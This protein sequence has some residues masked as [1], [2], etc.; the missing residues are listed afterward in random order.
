MLSRVLRQPLTV[1]LMFRLGRLLRA[2]GLGALVG[3]ARRWLARGVGDRVV[4]V[5]PD[6]LR[7][8]GGFDHIPQLSRLGHGRYEPT[9]VDLFR[10]LVR[11][12][13]VVVD[14]GA[15]IGLY[16]V[17]AGLRAGPAGRVIAVEPDE[18][19]L[20]HLRANVAHNRLQNV[21]IVPVA[22]AATTG[23][24]RLYAAAVSNQSTLVG[25]A[26]DPSSVHHIAEVSTRAIDDLVA[27]AH[28]DLVKL[29]VEG[30]EPA[31]LDGMRLTLERCPDL[32]LLVEFEPATLAAAATDPG[33]FLRRLQEH[34]DQVLVVDE[35][36]RGLVDA[37][38]WMPAYTQN[39]LCG[40]ATLELGLP[41]L[42]GIA[43]G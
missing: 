36:R 43:G 37:A 31:A 8:Q 28:V 32:I 39:L 9:T 41:I 40:P 2:V 30:G 12:G 34:F 20:A 14:V 18:R 21:E 15:S 6:G 42:E 3:A 17:L 19:S 5:T 11:P 38:G 7:F 25:G 27:G 1:S 23:V 22:A 29:D 4:V 26:L 33:A 16:T 10:S 13:A 24:G 35:Q